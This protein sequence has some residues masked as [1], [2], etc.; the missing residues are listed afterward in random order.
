MQN[1]PPPL[2]FGLAK[3]EIVAAVVHLVIVKVP[4]SPVHAP[5][6]TE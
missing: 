1:T 6:E 5:A 4:L 3:S 2:Q